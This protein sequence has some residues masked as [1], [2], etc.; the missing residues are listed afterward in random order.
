MNAPNAGVAFVNAFQAGQE[1]KR[2]QAMQEQ[3]MR[4]HQEDRQLQRDQMQQAGIKAQLDQHRDAIKTGAAIIRQINPKDQAGWDQALAA[5]QQYGITPEEIGVP[6]QF[7]ANYAQQI[8]AL[9]NALEPPKNPQLVPF[10]PGGGVAAYDPSN[11][12]VR[13]LVQPNEGGQVA[14]SPVNTPQV[15]TDED[16]MKLEGGQSGAGPAGNF[17]PPF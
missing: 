15:L 7:D 10:T 12:G 3:Q 9:A 1:A 16:M 11:G 5:A 14:G 4:E 6:R 2:Q 13:V 8:V 17:Q